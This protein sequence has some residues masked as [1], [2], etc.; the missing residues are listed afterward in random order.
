MCDGARD[1]DYGDTEARII[2]GDPIPATVGR[3]NREP[4]QTGSNL[5]DCKWTNRYQELLSELGAMHFI[6]GTRMHVLSIVA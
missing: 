5:H 6:S 1:V 4:N 3:M 2:C